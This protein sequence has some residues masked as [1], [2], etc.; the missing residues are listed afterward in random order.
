MAF[1][2]WRRRG[3]SNSRSRSPQTNDLANHPL[4]PLGYPS[5]HADGVRP[6]VPY[7]PRLR[8]D[9]RGNNEY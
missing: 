2:I 4:K 7:D 9:N 5:A 6:I 8:T 3:D 1:L